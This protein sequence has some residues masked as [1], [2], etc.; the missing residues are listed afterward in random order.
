M[1]ETIEDIDWTIP[2]SFKALSLNEMLGARPKFYIDNLA[3]LFTSSMPRLYLMDGSW[4]SVQA[5]KW[6]HSYPD[7]V[8]DSYTHVEVMS[9]VA[10][11]PPL[12]QYGSPAPD[13]YD[14]VL[15]KDLMLYISSRGGI[16][17]EKTFEI[18]W[19]FPR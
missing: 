18:S 7:D 10:L 17:R 13:V 12:D 19:E 9:E 16:D 5:G 15:L 14:Y 6:L 11:P 3:S 1:T 8:A 2:E 4:M